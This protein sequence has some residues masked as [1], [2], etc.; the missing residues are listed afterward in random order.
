MLMLSPYL[1]FIHTCQKD[2]A[3]IDFSNQAAGLLFDISESD[4][5]IA[6]SSGRK[7]WLGHVK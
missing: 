1:S 2:T 6:G 4:P 7:A 3:A 5:M